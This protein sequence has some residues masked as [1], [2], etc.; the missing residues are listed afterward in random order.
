[1]IRTKKQGMLVVLSGP[2]G[3]GKGT[4]IQEFLKKNKNTWLS[5]SATSRPQRKGD[6][7]GKTYYFLSKEAF[8]KQIQENAFLEY[9]SYAGNY[10]STPKA[11]IKEKLEQGIDVLLE[12]EI[13]GALKIKE[14]LPETI[15]IFILPPSMQEL[16]RRLVK[17]N[18]EDSKKIEKR[19]QRAYIEINEVSKYNYVIVNDDVTVAAEKVSAILL[20]ERLRVDRIEEVFLD[21]IEEDIHEELIAKKF[22]DNTKIEEKIETKNRIDSQ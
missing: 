5:V 16:K 6:V 8:E 11:P 1:M 17:R 4:V 18:T 2:S 15:F 9:A 13:Q 7:E 22:F 20:A 14:L 3:C 19:F 12:I 21:T 10:Y